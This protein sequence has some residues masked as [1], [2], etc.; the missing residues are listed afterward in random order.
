VIARF[1]ECVFGERVEIVFAV[2]KSRKPFRTTPKN[3]LRASNTAYWAF[4]INNS[5]ASDGDT[6]AWL[7]DCLLASFDVYR[8]TD[9]SSKFSRGSR[10][11]SLLESP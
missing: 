2:N 3:G 9:A 6:E 7:M 1:E 5:S 8:I 4:V 10:R 11:W